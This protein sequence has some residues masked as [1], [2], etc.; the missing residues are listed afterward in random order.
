MN[1]TRFLSLLLFASACST[2]P[3]AAP[4]AAA[5][6]AAPA[7]PATSA[8]PEP[9][10]PPA[11]AADPNE[12]CAQI[13]VVAYR[14]ANHAAASLERPREAAETR[15]RE[16]LRKL[17]QGADFAELAKTSSDAKSSAP[18][19]GIIG[20]FKKDDW[21][22]LHASIRDT[23]FELAVGETSKAPVPADYGYTIVRRCPV[24]KARSRHILVRYKGAKNA[25][26]A[27]RTKDQAQAR[28]SVL[29]AKLETGADFATLARAESDDSS[30]E[31]GGDIGLRPRGV[32]AAAYEDALF[33]LTPNS[34][35]GIVESEFGFHIIERLP[36]AP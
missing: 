26:D 35:S 12:A 24:E 6:P 5:A 9:A 2:P 32:L 8:A 19:A 23:V 22:A 27:K 33:A 18:R 20:A 15:A 25:D 4:V 30:K 21:P 29:L 14:G 11:P 17:K 28:A 34:R 10:A 31:R 36:D 16:L 7:P 1:V 3:E 13:I